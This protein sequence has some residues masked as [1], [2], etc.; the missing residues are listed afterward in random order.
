MSV[1]NAI[2]G[3]LGSVICRAVL[4]SLKEQLSVILP[5][6]GLHLTR[7]SIWCFI[8]VLPVYSGLVLALVIVEAIIKMVTGKSALIP[9]YAYYSFTISTASL[10]FHGTRIT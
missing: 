4:R 5:I 1:I 2:A 9:G 7:F 8:K 10:D 6:L 3:E